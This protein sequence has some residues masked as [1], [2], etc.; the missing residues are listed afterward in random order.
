MGD[1]RQVGPEEPDQ[2]GDDQ[3][4]D[5]HSAHHPRGQTGLVGQVAEGKQAQSEGEAGDRVAVVVHL[6]QERD[7]AVGV[8]RVESVVGGV[9]RDEQGGVVKQKVDQDE[10]GAHNREDHQRLLSGPVDVPEQQVQ[11]D[12]DRH[13]DR[14]HCDVGGEADP[15]QGRVGGAVLYGGGRAAR[16][17]D[18]GMDAELGDAGQDH[19]E[20]VQG[21][22]CAGEALGR[23]DEP[24]AINRHDLTVAGHLAGTSVCRFEVSR[25]RERPG[26]RLSADPPQAR[27]LYAVNMVGNV[28]RALW[29][30]PRPAHP[31]VRVWRDWALVAVLVAWSVL[32]T[33]LR[34]DLAWRPLV[35]LVSVVVALTM[36]WRRAIRLAA[37]AVGFGTL[38]AFDVAKIFAIDGTGLLSFAALLVL[39]TGG[40]GTPARPQLRPNRLTATSSSL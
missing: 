4:D 13:E 33:L 11:G 6:Q 19:H 10:P 9:G 32:E 30:E 27:S 31:P 16:Y 34:Q 1:R 5:E 40:P 8:R 29:A 36:L 37:V 3:A 18:A 24:S 12:S 39:P 7:E 20:Q 17:L 2:R 28:L 25:P 14:C 21:S 26:R 15:D 23:G 38:I 22:S 35:S